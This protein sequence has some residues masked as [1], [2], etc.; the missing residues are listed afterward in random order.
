MSNCSDKYCV[1]LMDTKLKI[2]KCASVV[3]QYLNTASSIL[4]IGN[5]YNFYIYKM[6]KLSNTTKNESCQSNTHDRALKT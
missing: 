4:I 5:I 2:Y 3:Q 1:P 6:N